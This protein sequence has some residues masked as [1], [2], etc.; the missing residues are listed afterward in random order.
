VKREREA[1]RARLAESIKADFAALARLRAALEAALDAADMADARDLAGRF[2]PKAQHLRRLLAAKAPETAPPPEALDA[3]NVLADDDRALRLALPDRLQAVMSWLGR[4]RRAALA[5]LGD[6][7]RRLRR[8]ARLAAALALAAC[9]VAGG[10]HAWLAY[11]KRAELAARSDF[12]VDLVAAPEALPPDFRAAGLLS[13][14]RDGDHVW[15]WGLGPQTVLAFILHEPRR[16]RLTLQCNN[17]VPGQTIAVTANGRQAIWELPEARPWMAGLDDFSLTFDG[18]V[19]LNAVVVDYRR[20]NQSGVA[21][22]PADP[23]NYAA[24]FTAISLATERP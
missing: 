1:A 2:G 5:A 13:V 11:A 6:G 10:R 17:P 15:R 8:L 12:A 22:A 20:F 3:W 23:T 24:A 7:R 16:V 19:G 21:F 14:E 4:R 18:V 9:L